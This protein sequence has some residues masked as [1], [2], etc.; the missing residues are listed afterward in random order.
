MKVD[1]NMLENLAEHALE[2]N[3][4]NLAIMLHTYLGARQMDMDGELAKHCQD[5]AKRQLDSID[6]WENRVNN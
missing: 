5:W 3:D 2:E 1:Y 4:H 6:M